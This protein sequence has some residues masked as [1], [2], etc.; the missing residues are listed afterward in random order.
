ML[1]GLWLPAV[2]YVTYLAS[3]YVAACF[4]PSSHFPLKDAIT[5][6]IGSEMRRGAF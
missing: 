4:S 3:P 1:T 2:P 6:T 5:K